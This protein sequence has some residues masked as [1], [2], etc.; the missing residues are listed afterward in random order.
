MKSGHTSQRSPIFMQIQ[1][2]DAIDY[3]QHIQ[4]KLESFCLH[5]PQTQVQLLEPKWRGWNSWVMLES[6]DYRA[7]N[8]PLTD[9][10]N[11]LSTAWE[12][13]LSNRP[14]ATWNSLPADK[15][16]TKIKENKLLP[17]EKSKPIKFSIKS[18]AS[19]LNS[20]KQQQWIGGAD[21]VSVLK[22]SMRLCI[23]QYVKYFCRVG[24]CGL[25]V[26]DSM[27]ELPVNS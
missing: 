23:L 14:R 4:A 6:S 11:G 19:K 8:K 26:T 15:M 5:L 20:E 24:F 3:S 12:N 10:R 27:S 7:T 9:F 21:L 22:E 1:C 16:T 25:M 17:R 18:N 13:N 2:K